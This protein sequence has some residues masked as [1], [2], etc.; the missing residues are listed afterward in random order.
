MDRGQS[1]SRSRE[2]SVKRRQLE[3]RRVPAFRS[4]GDGGP[5]GYLIHRPAGGREVMPVL[6]AG[7]RPVPRARPVVEP[8]LQ[9]PW[10]PRIARGTQPPRIARGTQPV[11]GHDETDV[12]LRLHQARRRLGLG[13]W[14]ALALASVFFLASA[15]LWVF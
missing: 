11:V 7:T 12:S 3:A 6:P 10:P 5:H 13:Y 14:I 8:I 9:R 1:R 15:A 4:L 2:D